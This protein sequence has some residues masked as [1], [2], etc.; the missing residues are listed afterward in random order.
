MSFTID[1]TSLLVR[2]PGAATPT[3]IAE[4][5]AADG[6]TLGVP[7]TNT[8]VAEWL[9]S[10]A[11]GAPSSFADPADHLVAGLGATLLDGQRID[12]HPSPRR[13]VGPDL[14]A[15]FV[16]ANERFGVIKDAWLRVHPKGARRV[17]LPV[18]NLELDP[19]LSSEE[20][21]LLQAIQRELAASP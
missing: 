21:T 14:I 2:V 19:P 20:D 8:S 9:A 17:A 15:L 6:L 16:G 5:P 10:G 13:A 18:E 1:R 11:V 3:S 12:V 4:A 7:I